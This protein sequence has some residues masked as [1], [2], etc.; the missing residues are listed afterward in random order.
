MKSSQIQI[1]QE[2]VQQSK[3]SV[4]DL[5]S[6]QVISR[7]TLKK[8][9]E[10]INTVLQAK[11][12]LDERKIYVSDQDRNICYK[13]LKKHNIKILPYY[14][15]EN[16]QQL[17]FLHMSL[18]ELDLNLQEL[19]DQLLVSKNTALTD[20]KR[21]REALTT[22][23]IL[24][25]YSR[26]I[27]YTIE[28]PEFSIRNEIVNSLRG[29]LRK[30]FSRYLLLEA[31]Y[32]SNSE[33]VLLKNRLLKIQ[34]QVKMTFTE[35]SLEEL[36]ILLSTLI[37]RAQQQRIKW[38]FPFEKYDI[39]NTSEYPTYRNVFRGMPNLNENDKLYMILQI[40]SSTFL[41]INDELYGSGE[42][43][44][45]INEFVYF[46]ENGC[47]MHFKDP[48]TL[49]EK[50]ALHLKPA[51]FRSL[52]SVN[53]RNP[54]TRVIMEEY[55]ALYMKISEGISMIEKKISCHFSNEEKA[56]IA[57][58]VISSMKEIVQDQSFKPFTALVLCRSGMS[59]SKLLQ[60][61]LKELFPNIA[62]AGTY[63]VD[64]ISQ[65]E[66]LPDF[67]FTTIPIDTEITT[68]VIPSVLDKQAKQKIQQQVEIAI[69]QDIKKKTK[70][71]YGLLDD[72]FPDGNKANAVK[73]IE[74]FYQKDTGNTDEEC[75]PFEL[76]IEQFSMIEA[77]SWQEVFQFAFGKLLERGSVNQRYVE[78]TLQLFEEDY[79]FMMIAKDCFLPHAKPENDVFKP[80]YQLVLVKN[81]VKFA[82]ERELKMMIA[83]AP[84]KQN[85]HVEWLLKINDALL[86]E[87]NI[88]QIEEISTIETFYDLL[89]SSFELINE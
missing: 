31:G 34:S 54:L 68:F 81:K 19:A 37:K 67:I 40:L 15:A 58:I 14:D 7:C 29:L 50:L 1:I 74:Q 75:N 66:V 57:M 72:L 21:L 42:V 25:N 51:I 53:I 26:K 39:V 86:Q 82:G 46:L 38:H 24:I 41:Q 69:N 78:R 71:L 65:A 56:F 88:R 64:E 27:G 35:E 84:S 59:I 5:L 89:K 61:N 11:L 62:F 10:E 48:A 4:K 87:K 55:S 33:I 52:L 44:S 83:L 12:K 8:D 73:R 45:A 63:A 13:Y 43:E 47:L 80:D 70:E 79:P 20:V 6:R 2:C 9:V 28:G 77:D 85:E 3:I 49:K 23:G 30:S 76:K 18:S 16:R 32:T 60:E 36:P 17:L 22:Q